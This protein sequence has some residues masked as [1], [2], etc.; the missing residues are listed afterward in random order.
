MIQ[1]LLQIKANPDRRGLENIDKWSKH[2]N[3][4]PWSI[5]SSIIKRGKKKLP[6]Y[7]SESKLRSTSYR[8][9]IGVL[10]R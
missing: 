2:H 3:P 8:S 9:K 5:W 7:S 1:Y 6:D 10:K 4:P